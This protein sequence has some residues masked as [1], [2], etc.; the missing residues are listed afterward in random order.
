[1]KNFFIDQIHYALGQLAH[2]QFINEIKCKFSYLQEN[3]KLLKMNYS[4]PCFA[5]FS[6]YTSLSERYW[7]VS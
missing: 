5:K 1:M 6:Q 2:N 7:G 3:D 4:I